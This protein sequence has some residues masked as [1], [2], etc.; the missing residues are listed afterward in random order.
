LNK[1]NAA[2]QKLHEFWSKSKTLESIVNEYT[3][4]RIDVKP[5]LARDIK[6]LAA[7]APSDEIRNWLNSAL[8]AGSASK[9]DLKQARDAVSANPASIS[10]MQKLI[11]LETK[12]G[13][14]VMASYLE[15]RLEQ[16]KSGRAM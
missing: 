10:D 5:V 16:S 14:P 12:T 15:K 1:A 13:H 7:C 3:E 6:A 2:N 11:S 9:T 8:S 4:S